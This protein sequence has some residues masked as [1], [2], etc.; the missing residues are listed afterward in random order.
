MHISFASGVPSED[1]VDLTVQGVKVVAI[2]PNPVRRV[3]GVGDPQRADRVSRI[4]EHQPDACVGELPIETFLV[5]ER[6]EGHV[7]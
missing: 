5:A 4:D 2:R 7:G 3:L 1:V 6:A